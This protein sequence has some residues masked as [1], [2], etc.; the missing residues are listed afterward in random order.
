MCFLIVSDEA[1]HSCVIG[2][3]DDVVGAEL[4]SAVVSQQC[5]EQWAEHK[6]FAQCGGAGGV[7]ANTD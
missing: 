3:L 5:E 4:S 7:A 1:Y 2:K 6:A